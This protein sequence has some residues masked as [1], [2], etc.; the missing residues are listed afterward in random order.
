[1]SEDEAE[2]F[3]IPTDDRRRYIRLDP[4][5]VNLAPSA[6]TRWFQLIGV[7]LDNGTELYPNGDE[8]QVTVPWQPP[9]TWDGLS[10]DA[11]NAALDEIETGLPNGQ[12]YSGGPAAKERA[13]WTVVHQYC[14]DKTEKQCRE[15]IKTWQQNGVL[16]AEEYK[17]PIKRDNRIG[18]R[19]NPTKRPG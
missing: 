11:L 12:R 16:Y 19:L 6:K 1:M 5:K 10:T 7:K 14:P 4:G 3:G 18:L 13:A 15:I 9:E 8:I 17:D 2:L